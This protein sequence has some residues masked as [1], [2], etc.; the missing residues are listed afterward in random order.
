MSNGELTFKKA[1]SVVKGYDIPVTEL[2]EYCEAVVYIESTIGDVIESMGW[3][4]A[5]LKWQ[6]RQ[7][8]GFIE[9]IYEGDNMVEYSP[10][11]NKAMEVLERLKAGE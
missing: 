11:I 7:E 5:T 1:V 8:K 10:A 4:I 6:F 2:Q 3:M 9:S